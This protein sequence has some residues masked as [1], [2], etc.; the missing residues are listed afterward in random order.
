MSKGFTFT[1]LA[2]TASALGYCF[3]F[4]YQRRHNP[5]FRKSI[6]KANRKANKAAEKAKT[7]LFDDLKQKLNESL[8]SDPIPTDLK[9]K[10]EYF[11]QQVSIGE[12]V[13]AM[14]G[15]EVDAAIYFYK[16]LAVYPNPT[17]LLEIYQRT[18]PQH[19]YDLVVMLTAI[20]PP[21]SISSIIG[22]SVSLVE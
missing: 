21:Q 9:Q 5:E 14:P 7:F 12:K 6:A 18:V 13:A 16:G 8:E 17:G 22:D 4:D 19:I 15:K 1:A 3:Y 2:L 10:E 11:L 20:Q